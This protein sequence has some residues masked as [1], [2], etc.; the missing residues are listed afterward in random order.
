MSQ[1]YWFYERKEGETAPSPLT[2]KSLMTTKVFRLT[3]GNLVLD[4]IN[5]IRNEGVRHI[6]LVEEGSDRLVG[7]VTETDILRNVLHGKKMTQEEEYHATLDLMLELRDIMV[8]NVET[9]MPEMTVDR[10]VHLFLTKRIRCVPI[11]DE[12]RNLQGII[13][14]TDL[15]MLLK[16][17]IEP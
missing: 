15:M 13:T 16:H 6:P 8:T 7:L 10:V 3:P 1:H 14:E 4:A 12:K 17:M 2:V 9:L 11:V 5:L